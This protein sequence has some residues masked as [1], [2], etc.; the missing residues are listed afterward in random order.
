MKESDSLQEPSNVSYHSPLSRGAQTSD[1]TEAD[2]EGEHNEGEAPA[3]PGSER[4]SDNKPSSDS[5]SS[6]WGD[7][8]SFWKGDTA[9]TKT[10][11]PLKT[12]TTNR[13]KLASRKAQSPRPAGSNTPSQTP[14]SGRTEERTAQQTN[15][16]SEQQVTPSSLPI[17]STPVAVSAGD[18]MAGPSDTTSVSSSSSLPTSPITAVEDS[19]NTRQEEGVDCDDGKEDEQRTSDVSKRT[20]ESEVNK[21]EEM[22]A[23]C[24]AET[25]NQTS[26]E[27][28]T[29][30]HEQ[31]EVMA[32]V[33]EDD[34]SDNN[35]PTDTV[36]K[37][38]GEKE[39]ASE[40]TTVVVPQEGEEKDVVRVEP[41]VVT[42]A[43]VTSSSSSNEREE[44][45]TLVT[46][47][48][49]E[50]VPADGVKDTDNVEHI[51][52]VQFVLYG[53]NSC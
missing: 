36:E 8:S 46:E 38:E 22:L 10:S 1:S 37:D 2:R 31:S 24:I 14:Q 44:Q 25:D 33:S 39:L 7:T 47:R 6:T 45:S 48:E 19:S 20:D 50:T 49:K 15:P 30:Q 26:R 29:Q 18:K 53:H 21:M 43:S 40:S 32:V 52:E 9:K 34:A 51:R 17:I 28:D 41:P 23:S 13:T 27:T 35:S 5:F 42:L 11:T 3:A 4:P 16:P 12:D